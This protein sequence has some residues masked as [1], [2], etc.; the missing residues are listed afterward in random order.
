MKQRIIFA[1]K[2]AVFAGIATGINLG[3]QKLTMFT[4]SEIDIGTTV[5]S[6]WVFFTGPWN[7]LL[8]IVMGTGLGL[9]VKYFL[10]KKYIFVYKTDNAKHDGKLFFLYSVMGIFTTG[11]YMLAELGF[12]KLFNTEFMLLV[13]AGIGLTIG[14]LV[15]YELD[16]RFVFVDK[17]E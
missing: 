1:T 7:M 14:Y 15:K 8:G 11:I 3:S 10:D 12:Y 17:K 16:R 2:Y 9:L 5:I 13:G 6:L 4:L